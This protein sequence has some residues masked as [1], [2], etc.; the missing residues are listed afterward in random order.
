MKIVKLIGKIFAFIGVTLAGVLLSLIIMIVLIC[1]GPSTSAKDLFATTLLETGQLKFLANMFLSK[2]EIEEILAKNSMQ[3]MESDV[4]VD[5]I[6]VEDNKEK[7]L[8]EIKKISGNGFEGTLMIVNDPSKVSLATT[9]PWTEYG[10]VLGELVEE[11]NALAG[12]NGGLYHSDANKGGR[13]MG[14]TVQEGKI[15]DLNANIAGLHLIGFDEKNI[16]RIIDLSGMSNNDVK[17]LIKKE[18]I[19]DAVGFQEE[20]S[21]K[22]NHFVKLI[23]NGEVRQMNGLGSGANPRTVIGQRKDGSVLLLVTD[24]RGKNGHLGATAADLIQIMKKYGAVNAANLDGGSSSSMYY[25]GEY[26]MTSVTFYYSN[27][28]WRLPTAFVVKDGN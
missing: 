8:I 9:Y 10:K 27:S 11:N 1:H 25:K 22:N 19:R 5:L 16:L 6:K 2:S 26:L 13:P 18:K 15:L 7:E 21:D 24:G 14:I 20:A 4:D 28:S 17:E 3:E 23:I 12:I